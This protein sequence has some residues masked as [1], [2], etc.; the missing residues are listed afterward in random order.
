M[1]ASARE[2]L[3]ALGGTRAFSPGKEMRDRI[4]RGLNGQQ[5]RAVRHTEG[6]LLIFAGAG[7]GKTRVIV[8]RVAHLISQGVSPREILC[9]TFTNKAA[10]EMKDRLRS[11]L[12]EDDVPVWAG[13]F[14]AFGAWFL[15]QEA[16]RVGY[17]ANFV[18]YD[19]ADQRSLIST[20]LKDLGM[21]PGRGMCATLAWLANFA[22]DTM[23]DLNEIACGLPFDP[24]PVLALYEK[25]KRENRALDFADLLFAPL[26]MLSADEDL[27]D[28]YRSR[29]P[30]ILVDEYQDTNPAQ[31]LLLMNLVGEGENLCVVGD[32]DQSIYGWRGADMGNIL[33]FRDDFPAAGVVVLEQNYRSTGEILKAASALISH[34]E[35]RVP[36][37]L[38]PVRG[39]G[40]KVIVREFPDSVM[41]ATGIA[42]A[43]HRLVASGENPAS[44]GVLYRVNSLS[45]VIEEALAQWR[46]PYAVHRGMR[47]YERREIRD[48]LAY[49]RILVNPR[50]E[51]ALAR[52]INVPHRGVG[53]K[54]VNALRHYARNRGI[55]IVHALGEAVMDRTAWGAGLKGLEEFHRIH[56]EIAC[57]AGTGDIAS[58]LNDILEVTGY[59]EAL[60]GEQ[61]GR[62]R[63]NNIREL[64]AGTMNVRDIGRYLEEKALMSR[65]TGEP[66]ERV[67]IMTLHMSKG[68]EFDH[69]FVPGLEE[70]ILPH[71][72]CM[73]TT[74]EIEEE[75]RLLYVGI[76]RARK[77]VCLSW[78]RVRRIYGREEFQNP[79]G[80]IGEILQEDASLA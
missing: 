15:R 22:R 6:P 4:L 33:K 27:R 62:E 36:K 13:T 26:T 76:T 1:R 57:R 24:Y 80:F 23:Q 63:M 56:T 5:E 7:S 2:A 69:V 39:R 49:L 43:I 28:G 48:M 44:I 29:F 8:H 47:F 75:R 3:N 30:Y 38:K 9:L 74:R 35:H 42:H 71:S 17:P 12:G 41:E 68:L 78:S 25:R 19:E 10:G 51:E 64:I 50:D 79:S 16:F 31:Y 11:I 52:V 77:E 67:S 40:K 66:G 61:D 20:C 46:I 18:I 21:K 37:A 34:N 73:D 14:H 70:G 58:L 53:E 72:R 65:M 59:E 54:T 55:P 60:K 32:D 45:R